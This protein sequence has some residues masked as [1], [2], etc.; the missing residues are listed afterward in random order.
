[1]DSARPAPRRIRPVIR[2]RLFRPW[3]YESLAEAEPRPPGFFWRRA[4]AGIFT[5]LLL[6][7]GFGF[8]YGTRAAFI[9]DVRLAG[10]SVDA[11]EWE[12]EERSER[13]THRDEEEDE[14]SETLEASMASTA[15]APEPISSEA[16]PETVADVDEKDETSDNQEVS[17]AEPVTDAPMTEDDASAQTP[18][19]PP[20]PSEN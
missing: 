20:E 18:A 8:I 9:L 14:V 16:E 15:F 10:H 7:G 17:V 6:F 4:K 3:I 11:G 1:M 2:P 19:P 13:R 12:E 5:A